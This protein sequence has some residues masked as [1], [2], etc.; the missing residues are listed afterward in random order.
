MFLSLWPR[1]NYVN[2]ILSFLFLKKHEKVNIIIADGPNALKTKMN[3]GRSVP[4][5]LGKG[6]N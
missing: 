4:F 2:P 5:A 1:Q 3:S 6:C